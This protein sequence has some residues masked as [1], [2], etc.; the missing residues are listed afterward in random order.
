MTTLK[1]ILRLCLFL[2]WILIILPFQIIVV[3]FSKGPAITF[4]PALWH[5]GVCWMFGIKVDIIGAP[6]SS[7]PVMFVSNHI[8]YLDIP[9]IGSV[10]KASF[11][12]KSEVADWP[13]FGPLSKIA[14]TV[15]VKRASKDAFKDN[16][17]LKDTLMTGRNVILF[18]EGT[19]SNGQQVLPF[20]STLFALATHDEALAKDLV[21][22]PFTVKLI[23]ADRMDAVGNKDIYDLYAWY[24]DMTLAPHLWTLAHKKGAHI[25]LHFHPSLKA[26]DYEDRKRLA[27]D[28]EKMVASPLQTDVTLAA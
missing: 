25:E 18:P 14:Q 11:V 13:L 10:V 19:S 20:K 22:Q 24:D 2:S 15:F 28:C 6:E 23:S 26:A 9:V 21:I 27:K 12:A 5:R 17:A 16:N 3:L 4:F 1:A 8:S 7:H